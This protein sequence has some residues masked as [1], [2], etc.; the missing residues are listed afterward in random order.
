VD[1]IKKFKYALVS[2]SSMGV[3][4]TP[5]N[6]QPIHTSDMFLIRVSSAET[7]VLSISAALGLQTKVLTTFVEGSPIAKLIKND[8]MRRGIQFEGKEV[9]Q[10]G[11][12]GY[13]HQFNIADSGYGLLAPQVHNDRTGEVGKTL[14]LNDFDTKRLFKEE[15]VQMLHLSGLIISLSKE[16][17]EFCLELARIAKVY[18]TKISFDL[19]YR[20]SFWC[21]RETE[22]KEVFTEIA[23]LSD[24]IIGNEEDFQLALGIKGP[25]TGG[26]HI[27]DEIES[28]KQMIYNVKEAFPHVEICA[29]T[30]R[31]VQ[32]ANNHLWGALLLDHHKWTVIQPRPIPVLD[33]IGGG[34]GFV[35]G[36]LYGLLKG[37]DSTTSTQFGWATGALVTSVL[38]DYALPADEAQVWD[39][40]EGNARVQR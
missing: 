40:W 36:L 6:R 22:L 9:K 4:M 38:E 26:K 1:F 28:F 2:P 25:K 27:S 35:G 14:D 39:I 33:R 21:N 12:W 15:G 17:Q 19:N 3:R 11:P 16:T 34:D 32:S 7:N 13:R 18:G 31:E 29:T 8:L 20:D 24:I 10:G 37:W 5:I 30:L 23:S